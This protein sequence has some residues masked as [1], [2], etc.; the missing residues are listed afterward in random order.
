MLEAG[1]DGFGGCQQAPARRI[2]SLDSARRHLEPWNAASKA[3][4]SRRSFSTHTG[5][6]CHMRAFRQSLTASGPGTLDWGE[7]IGVTGP[8]C[9]RFLQAS[10]PPFGAY[11]CSLHSPQHR[12]QLAGHTDQQGTSQQQNISRGPLSLRGPLP[13]LCLASHVCHHIAVPYR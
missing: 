10:R 1:Q 6:E 4:H 5:R 3:G 8:V 7:R 2:H 12:Y 13:A 9:P 11:R